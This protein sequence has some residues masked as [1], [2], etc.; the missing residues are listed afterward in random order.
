MVKVAKLTE[1]VLELKL[2]DSMKQLAKDMFKQQHVYLEILDCDIS[3]INAIRGILCSELPAKVLDCTNIQ[4]SDKFILIDMLHT[5]I[6]QICIDQTVRSD[7]LF[8]LTKINTTN[9]I[10]Q[11][12]TDDIKPVRGDKIPYESSVIIADL[13]PGQRIDIDNL[14]VKIGR[15]FEDSCFKLTAGVPVVR[16]INV[17]MH[18]AYKGSGVKSSEFDPQ[19]NSL[20]FFTNGNIGGIEALKL[21]INI[22]ID[23][24]ENFNEYK[25]VTNKGD[26]YEITLVGESWY[27]ATI[28]KN[29]MLSS[30]VLKHASVR[31]VTNTSPRKYQIIIR[32][33]VNIEK[34]LESARNTA[35]KTVKE[36]LNLI[37]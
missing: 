25:R 3:Y 19:D 13:Q 23:K 34:I 31:E 27:V 28:L 20:E 30:V 26:E 4:C 33:D 12:T 17:E 2:S 16:P 21:A 11:I 9:D 29:V 10:I 18:D 24:L 14:F 15:G 22:L 35:I 37:A 8:K 32:G 5:R 1:E 36:I 6:R 7:E